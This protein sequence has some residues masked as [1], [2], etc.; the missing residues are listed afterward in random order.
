MHVA[1]NARFLLK[2][3]LEGIGRFTENVLQ[4]WVTQRPDVKFSFFFDRP[5]DIRYI[6]GANITAFSLFPP[7]RH[8]LLFIAFFEGA[9]RWKLNQ[10]KP[11][12]FF[13]PDG[14]LCLG[15]ATPQVAVFHDLAF[16]HFPEGIPKLSL[17][18]YRYF[19]PKYAQKA[20]RICCVSGY[21]AN[22]VQ[23][24]YKIPAEKIKIVYNGASDLFQPI[25]EAERQSV[26]QKYTRGAPYFLSVGA[27]HPRKNIERLLY[28]FNDFKQETGLPAKLLIIGR[29]AWHYENV[30][31]CYESLLH[32]EDIIFIGNLPDTE[33]S[34]IYASAIA[35]C[36][37]SLFEGF[38]LPLLEAMQT[39]TPLLT[40]NITSMP[41]V[42]GGAALL[43]NPY[44]TAAITAGLV[45][46]ATR[47]SLRQALVEQAR[48][49][50]QLFSWDKTANLCWEALEEGIA[51]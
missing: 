36:Y 50:K 1:V 28:A 10:L 39:H 20:R 18:H 30:L 49:Q 24:K 6:Y 43:V 35:L 47:P 2:P 26:R 33:L 37:V 16:E 38:G 14:Y 42:A 25:S 7:A 5:F 32:K 23:E 51:L 46:L 19:F 9:I 27:I 45:Q 15:S 34:K 11:D 31:R 41:E 44:D 3:P 48:L 12:V 13:S 17:K 40:S 22:D 4:R 8:P 29:K 21:T